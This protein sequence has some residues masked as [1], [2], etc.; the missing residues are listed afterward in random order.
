MSSSSSP[1]L[2]RVLKAAVLRGA[3]DVHVKAGDVFRARIEGE[4]VPLTKQRLTPQQTRALAAMFARLA[5]DDPRLDTLRDFDC[6]WGVAGRRPLSHQCAAPAVVVHDDPA[7]DS[8]FGAHTRGARPS[9][10]R[11]ASSPNRPPG[12]SW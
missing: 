12:S 11:Y 6:S 7:R 1:M 9:R 5:P 8:L 2:A 4:L 3:S 10:G